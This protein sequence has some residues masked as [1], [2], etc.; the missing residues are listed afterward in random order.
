MKFLAPLA[1]V[2]ALFA[3]PG[4]ALAQS[5]PDPRAGVFSTEQAYP[6]KFAEVDGVQMHY[7][8]GG[9]SKGQVFLFL[10][11][12]PTSSYLWRNVMPHVEPFGRVIA[13]DLIGFGKSDKPDSDYTFQDHSKYV[14]GF[15]KTLDLK[16]IVLVI[17]DWGS[18]LGFDYARRHTGN[19]KGIAF[20]E[21]LVPPAFPAPSYEA[22]GPIGDIFR[23]WRDPETGPALLIDQNMFIEEILLKGALTRELTEAEKDAYRAPFLDP[24]SRKPIY[25]WPNELPI[26]GKPA[27]NVEAVLKVGEWL[28][29]SQTPKLLL[30]ARPGAI[31][32]PESAAWMRANY[33]NIETVFVGYGSHYIQEDNPEVIGRNIAD[34]YDRTFAE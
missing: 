17:H 8:E 21:A 23:Q 28:Q 26:E 32:S 16:D 13:V 24:A 7:V 1:L 27:R 12:N 3:L 10:H 18:M 20:M 22:M 29:T 2:L 15:I 4:A 11:G 34:W 30:Y 5:A 14:D 31:V 9:N 19:V 6:S 25:V 33:K